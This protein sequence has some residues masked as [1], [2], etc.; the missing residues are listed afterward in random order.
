MTSRERTKSAENFCLFNSN[1]LGSYKE[2]ILEELW[3]KT[4]NYENKN[5]FSNDANVE[6]TLTYY[7]NIM[8]NGFI[9]Q[10]NSKIASLSRNLK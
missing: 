7:K 6:R 2:K 8:E 1:S 5:T 3:N 4:R 9:Q 10:G